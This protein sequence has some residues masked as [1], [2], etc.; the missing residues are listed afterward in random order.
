MQDTSAACAARNVGCTLLKKS[1][2]ETPATVSLICYGLMYLFC[3][4]A[5]FWCHLSLNGCAEAY[6]SQTGSGQM[7]WQ[8]GIFHH[9]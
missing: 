9:M 8:T 2:L 4:D 5:S 6:L 3:T 7:Q 1:L